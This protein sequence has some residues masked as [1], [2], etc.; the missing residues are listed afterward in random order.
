MYKV[1]LIG[2]GNVGYHLIQR[3]QERKVQ[4]VQVFTRDE[5]K[6]KHFEN[7]L[8]IPYITDLQALTH[9]ADLYI[10][11]VRDD[12]I[13]SVAEQMSDFLPQNA[14]VVHTSGATPSAILAPYFERFGS[15]YPFQSFSLQKKPNFSTIP[16]C[17]DATNLK[18]VAFLTKIAKKLSPNIHQI[19]DAQRG[20]LHVAA[21]FVNNFTNYLFTIGEAI[22][23]Q[24]QLPF[25]L[26]KP[27]ILETVEKIKI[28]SPSALQ[29]GPAI[30][31]DEQTIARHLDFLA[32]HHPDFMNLYATLTDNI[33]K[34]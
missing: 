27:L 22:T 8:H 24:H 9:E 19:T 15:L 30:R 7:T 2:S 13:A 11:A 33:R 26:L 4:V 18:D 34:I 1:A 6:A 12:S 32:A 3:F 20:V 23:T 16:I 21:V 5:G 14:F 25:D 17:I 29:T 10:I 31:G 28:H